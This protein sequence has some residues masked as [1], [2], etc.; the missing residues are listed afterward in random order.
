MFENIFPHTVQQVSDLWHSSPALGA[1]AAIFSILFGLAELLF[2]F[3]MYR[4]IFAMLL[5]LAGLASGLAMDQR[6]GT[7]GVCAISGVVLGIVVS[8]FTLRVSLGVACGALA[9]GAAMLPPI[10]NQYPIVGIAVAC[11]AFIA[12][13]SGAWVGYRPLLI[14][15]TSL[16]GASSILIGVW[17]VL[18]LCGGLPL[19][20]PR[21][22]QSLILWLPATF[23]A[24]MPGL[25]Y[26]FK[27]TRPVPQKK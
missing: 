13:A 21:P 12:A 2:G 23:L 16:G 19:S 4:V 17:S 18:M 15:C 26:Q 9:A 3:R 8:L 1:G 24:A 27:T 5:G 25:I 10:L 14:F 6:F 20:S 7:T 22:N 11:V